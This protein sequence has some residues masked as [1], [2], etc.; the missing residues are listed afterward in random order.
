MLF[1]DQQRAAQP[2]RDL[3]ETD[4]DYRWTEGWF[5]SVGQGIGTGGRKQATRH[6]GHIVDPVRAGGADVG[7][8]VAEGTWDMR[9]QAAVRTGDLVTGDAQAGGSAAVTA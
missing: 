3:I 1:P 8:I 6:A 9:A 5:A 2:V 4:P 7:G